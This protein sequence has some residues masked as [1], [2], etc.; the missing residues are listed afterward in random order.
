MSTLARMVPTAPRVLFADQLGPHFDDGG[1]LVIPEVLGPL[2]RRKYHRQ[3]AHL[4]LSALRHRVA[5]LGDRVD[6]RRGES[7]RDVLGGMDLEVINPTSY[8]L[9]R[10][11]GNFR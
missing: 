6:Y 10:L 11:V 2:R 8:G 1:P 4:I 7:Y 5:E 3:K 9:R